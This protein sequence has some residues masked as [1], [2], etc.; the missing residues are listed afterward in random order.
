MRVNE[1]LTEEQLEELDM[2]KFGKAATAAA[3]AATI[4]G[5]LLTG[6]PKAS[7]QQSIPTTVSSVQQQDTKKPEVQKTE[8]KKDGEEKTVSSTLPHDLADM[9]VAEKKKLFLN[10][11]VP[12]VKKENSEIKQNRSKLLT[13]LKKENLTSEEKEWLKSLMKKYKTDDIATLVWRVDIIPTS[14]VVAQAAIESGWGTSRFAREGNSLFGQRDYSGGGLS[15][16]GAKGFTVAKF[17]NIGDSIESYMNNLN[18]HG[19]YKGL[20]EI[21]K[22]MRK[23]GTDLNSLEMIPSLTKYSERGHSYVRDLSSIIKSNNLQKFDG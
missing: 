10:A 11:V 19:A 2:K 1:I 22:D 21:R 9:P 16:K 8:P 15:P 4:G 17:D 13:L 14:M 6:T 23:S 18:T 7:A 3:A 5:A 12:I 20:R